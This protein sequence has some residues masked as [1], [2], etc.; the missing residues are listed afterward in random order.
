MMKN[1]II[2]AAF[3][4]MVM[5][6]FSVTAQTQNEQKIS[7]AT[8]DKVIQLNVALTRML[9]RQEAVRNDLAKLQ[10]SYI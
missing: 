9:D 10:R 7:S 6:G 3:C 8:D 1:Y 4:L 5:C 2:K